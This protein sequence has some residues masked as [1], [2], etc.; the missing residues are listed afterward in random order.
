M[1]EMRA[2]L[3]KATRGLDAMLKPLEALQ[4]L[5]EAIG[6]AMDIEKLLD[7]Q[8]AALNQVKAE[9]ADQAVKRD[10]GAR[11]LVD[12]RKEAKDIAAQAKA[13]ADAT[14][15]NAKSDADRI[16]GVAREKSLEAMKALDD[17][18]AQAKKIVED[19]AA[20]IALKQDQMKELD[21][22]L[23]ALQAK[24]DSAKAE[25]ARLARELA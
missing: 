11:S 1:S 7:E 18:H 5:R 13:D 17:A 8:R 20:G 9:I 25:K 16:L 15:A 4:P 24:M 6:E 21:K 10:A 12:L 3:V 14:R 19:A 23:R 2:A 22:E